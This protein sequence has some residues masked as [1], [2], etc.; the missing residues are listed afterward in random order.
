MPIPKSFLAPFVSAHDS[1]EDQL[2]QPLDRRDPVHFGGGGA[3]Q[4]G[5]G[6]QGETQQGL[7][8]G[9]YSKVVGQEMGPA[10]TNQAMAT[11]P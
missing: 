2:H 4:R 8:H 10:I 5:N 9:D 1:N 11:V 3:G 7:Q 6:E